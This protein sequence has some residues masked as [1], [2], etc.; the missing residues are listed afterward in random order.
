MSSYPSFLEGF[1]GVFPAR[2]GSL[3]SSVGLP[4]G[5]TGAMVSGV[6]EPVTR[7]LNVQIV[8]HWLILFPGLSR[9]SFRE[10][11]PSGESL[12]VAKHLITFNDGG[13]IAKLP[14]WFIEQ[15][16]TKLCPLGPAIP[17]TR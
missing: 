9:L 3:G 15:N 10:G 13:L 14:P 11:K 8:C 1:R 16:S 2:M 7:V 5:A 6:I 12:S 17:A 4:T